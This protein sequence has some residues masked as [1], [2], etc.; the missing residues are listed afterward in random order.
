M[1]LHSCKGLS[2]QAVFIPG[3]EE[4]IIPGPFRARFASQAEEAARL[5]YVGVT[6]ARTLC[7]LS[8]ARARV[9]NGR[10]QKHNASR[11]LPSLGVTFQTSA[12]LTSA[13]IG[14]A[15]KHIHEL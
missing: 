11:F 1:T 14:E 13:E 15:V 10:T 7:V 2:A 6:R 12:G 8:F 5:L 3:L 9:M 4:E